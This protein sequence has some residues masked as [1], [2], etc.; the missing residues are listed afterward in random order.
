MALVHLIFADDKSRFTGVV[1]SSR[2]SE[3]PATELALL[4][5]VSL[6]LTLV[7]ILC[8]FLA[9]VAVYKVRFE[10]LGGFV[11]ITLHLPVRVVYSTEF[12]T[13]IHRIYSVD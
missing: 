8:I 3:D 9:G 2:Y 12:L 1:T 7:N 13:Y 5:T 10:V 11:G 4:G 6:C